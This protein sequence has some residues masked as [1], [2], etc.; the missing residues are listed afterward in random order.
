MHSYQNNLSMLNQYA[1]AF[2]I[3]RHNC[4]SVL[5]HE[6]R[7]NQQFNSK[8]QHATINHDHQMLRE[9]G[10]NDIIIYDIKAM[11]KKG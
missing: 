7:F 10:E 1:E 9:I 8:F 3:S 4:I 6:L 2:L 11:E 5:T